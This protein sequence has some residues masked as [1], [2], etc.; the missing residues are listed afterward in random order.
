M[1]NFFYSLPLFFPILMLAQAPMEQR[2]EI[3]HLK[4]EQGKPHVFFVDINRYSGSCE[5]YEEKELTNNFD[6]NLFTVSDICKYTDLEFP[7]ETIKLNEEKRALLFWSGK[8]NDKVV[9]NEGDYLYSTEFV[10]KQLGIHKES[11]YAINTKKWKEK[12][13]QLTK[14]NQPTKESEKVLKSLLNNLICKNLVAD[15]TVA[16]TQLF[17]M[18]NFSKIKSI[19]TSYQDNKN[20]KVIVAKIDFNEKGFPISIKERNSEKTTEFTY[21]GQLL[22]ET[23][24]GD[25][26]TNY[27]YQDDKIIS[28]QKDSD[29]K[30]ITVYW[31]DKDQLLYDHYSIWNDDKRENNN[32]FAHMYTE[33]NC[34]VTE[35]NYKTTVCKTAID[36]KSYLETFRIATNQFDR[37]ITTKFQNE[38]DKLINIYKSEDEN[39]NFDLVG[40]IRLNDKKLIENYTMYHDGNEIK[41]YY[42]YTFYP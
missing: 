32:Y 40:E 10:A 38:G 33:N 39:D 28:T 18:N 5:F 4:I 2:K 17:S 31:L 3:E 13:E 12:I 36:E 42:E 20:K 8:A 29:T 24:S 23:K 1:N 9:V 35:S 7:N 16:L 19:E 41:L 37:S 27:S 6:K 30:G 15:K 34:I 22:S 14:N 25:K 11:S 26:I 21:I